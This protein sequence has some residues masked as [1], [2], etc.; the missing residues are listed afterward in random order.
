VSK[1]DHILLLGDFNVT[2]SDKVMYDF[3]ESYNLK[4]LIS[5]PTCFKNP[6]NPSCI[7][8]CLTNTP[9][10]FQN[11][12]VIETG[13]SDFHKMTVVV[14]KSSFQRLKPKVIIYREYKNFTNESFLSELIK[15]LS[16]ESFNDDD[17]SKFLHIC[18]DSLNRHA[19]CKR[20]FVRG[21]Q[22]PFMNK[23]LSKAIMTRSRLRNSYLKNRTG[24]NRQKFVEQRNY[25]VS[26]L[27]KTK[28]TYY[29]N[30]DINDICDNKKFWK[31]TKPLFS[32]KIN[33]SEKIVLLENNELM[34]SDSEICETMNDFFVSI[35]S[36]LNLPPC[37][38][39]K[40]GN[41]NLSDPILI[42]INKYRN[43]PSIEA[44]NK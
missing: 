18:L 25:C 5:T 12:C 21:N 20:K 23:S 24:E 17:P 39:N 40:T 43:H 37:I 4:S 27:R 11:S 30:L 44:I 19:P 10:S 22:S 6:E 3:C 29:S 9:R 15:K 1:Y 38:Y 26:L 32:D 8:L 7:D 36:N 13:L 14:N 28:K 42:A 16:T 35:A 33:H 31:I 41:E 2:V 34:N